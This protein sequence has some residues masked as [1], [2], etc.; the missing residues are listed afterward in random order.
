MFAGNLDSADTINI[1]I[2]KSDGSLRND[3]NIVTNKSWKRAGWTPWIRT[4]VSDPTGIW[5]YQVTYG[6]DTVKKTFTLEDYDVCYSKATGNW[7]DTA[8]WLGN[9]VPGSSDSVIIRNG[10]DVTLDTVGSCY[11]LFV[12]GSSDTSTLT[13]NNLASLTVADNA[14][15]YASANNDHSLLI[16]NG[17]LNITHDWS[18]HS[19]GFTGFELE[20]SGVGQTTTETFNAHAF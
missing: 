3:W 8:T 4:S 6:T 2:W 18:L 10:H 16:N 19:N 17:S 14:H 5:S 20:L 7:R 15:C 12:N 1:K 11:R 13:I 9:R